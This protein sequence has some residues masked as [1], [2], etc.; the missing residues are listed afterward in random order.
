MTDLINKVFPRVAK[1]ILIKRFVKY[2]TSIANVL[3]WESNL[4]NPLVYE[5]DHGFVKNALDTDVYATFRPLAKDWSKY[6]RDGIPEGMELD[7]EFLTESYHIAEGQRTAVAIRAR[8]FQEMVREA[9]WGQDIQQIVLV[10]A[11]AESLPWRFQMGDHIDFYQAY[12]HDNHQKKTEEA[13]HRIPQHGNFLPCVLD[14][15]YPETW[16]QTLIDNGLDP[17]KKTCFICSSLSRVYEKEEQ[18]RFHKTLNVLPKG[19]MVAHEYWAETL[20]GHKARDIDPMRGTL[21]NFEFLLDEPSEMFD[22]DLWTT[23]KDTPFTLNYEK[24]CRVHPPATFIMV[25]GL[26]T[27]I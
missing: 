24:R 19:S 22:S 14:Y 9:I 7:P 12:F 16:L 10:N 18:Q 27:K 26:S 21:L 13:F 11:F 3:K 4:E 25:F 1:R 2:G 17:E 15:A 8:W 23:T 20:W 5:P 6:F